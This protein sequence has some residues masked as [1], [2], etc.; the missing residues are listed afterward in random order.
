LKDEG[1]AR[2]L[3]NRIQNLRKESG[4]DV[5]DKII[6]QIERHPTVNKAIEAYQDYIS[7]QI[8]AHTIKL[9]EKLKGGK[10][11]ELEEGVF[12]RVKIKKSE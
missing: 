9:E 2:E 8:L 5:T 3:V 11:M 12:V 1:I 4:Y 7:S 10:E 6:V